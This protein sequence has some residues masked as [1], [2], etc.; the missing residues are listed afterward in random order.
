MY[1]QCKRGWVFD[2]K[3]LRVAKVEQARLCMILNL[4]REPLFAFTDGENCLLLQMEREGELKE[5][6]EALLKL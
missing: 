1:V 2:F 5:E 3:P 4:W 6:K